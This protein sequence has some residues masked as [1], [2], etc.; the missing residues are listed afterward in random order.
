M[1]DLWVHS[2]CYAD[3]ELRIGYVR[4]H[5]DQN[6]PVNL[7]VGKL[8]FVFNKRQLVRKLRHMLERSVHW[9]GRVLVGSACTDADPGMRQVQQRNAD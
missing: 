9:R 3:P 5:A 8:G 6:M 2:R 1:P 7:L 4:R